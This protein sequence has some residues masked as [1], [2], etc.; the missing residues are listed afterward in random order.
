MA[1]W[2][3]DSSAYSFQIQSIKAIQSLR[4]FFNGDPRKLSWLLHITVDKEIRQHMFVFQFP[5]KNLWNYSK[6]EECN[7]IIHTW[8]MT[9][10]T[11]D[12]KGRNFLDLLNKERLP[13]TPTYM[14]GGAWLKHFSHSNTLCARAI[15]TITNYASIGE[16]YLWFFSKELFKCPYSVYPIESRNHILHQCMRH[17]KY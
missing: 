6:K 16:C 12:L 14:K 2:I 9:F 11:L 10:Q 3:F 4:V 15:R 8:Q 1:K 7:N 5:Y 17:N 13:I